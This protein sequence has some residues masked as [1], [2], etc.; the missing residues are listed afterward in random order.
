MVSVDEFETRECWSQLSFLKISV[1]TDVSTFKRSFLF[2]KSLMKMSDFRH[3]S[4]LIRHSKVI[5]FV[6]SSLITSRKSGPGLV[7]PARISRIKPDT[8]GISWTKPDP[9]RH[10]QTK[11]DQ[12]G[13]RWTQQDQARHSRTQLDSAG[14]SQTPSD[15]D[16]P[17]RT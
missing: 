10:S 9:A 14:P 12:A 4:R 2:Y 1:G 15:P 17:C 7:K 3:C 5:S 13:P 16:G 6:N 8:S 11:P